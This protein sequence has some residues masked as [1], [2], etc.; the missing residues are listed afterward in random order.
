MRLYLARKGEEVHYQIEVREDEANVSVIMSLV[1]R[2]Q[3]TLEERLP[4]YASWTT[5]PAY[6][7]YKKDEK[8]RW[9]RT[10]LSALIVRIEILQVL[11]SFLCNNT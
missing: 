6:Y 11:W 3:W 8:A 9:T 10:A 5:L 7:R 4:F 2:N 1:N